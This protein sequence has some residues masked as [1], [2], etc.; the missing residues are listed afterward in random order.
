MYQ[1]ENTIQANDHVFLARQKDVTQ[2]NARQTGPPVHS[3][4]LDEN[5]E[6]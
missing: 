5:V 3:E 1:S 2:G 6:E 4:T